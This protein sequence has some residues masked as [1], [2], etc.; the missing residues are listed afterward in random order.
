MEPKGSL[1]Q[2]QVPVTCPYPEPARSSPYPT[3]HF[4]KIHLNIILPSMP[5]SP[6]WSLSLRFPHQNPVYASPLLHMRHM[7]PSLYSRFNHP[8]NIWWAVQIIKLLIMQL[9][10]LPC[11]L[12]PPKPKYN[13]QHSMLKHSQPAFLPQTLTSY[14]FPKACVVKKHVLITV[15]FLHTL[16]TIL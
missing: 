14:N 5:G 6:K 12:I 1:P 11:H 13:P 8:N 16:A 3:S 10:P 15:C 9:P 4:L 7:R 2:S